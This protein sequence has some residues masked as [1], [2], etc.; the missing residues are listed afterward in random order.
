MSN[1]KHVLVAVDVT[2]EAAEV[3][4]KAKQA[5]ADSGAQ[6]SAI[7]VVRPLTHAYTGIEVAGL[8]AAAVNFEAEA[9]ASVEQSLGD[10]CAAHGIDAAHRQVTFGVPA[11]EIKQH[12]EDIGADLVVLGSHGRHGLGLLLGS[13]ANAVLHGANCDILTVRVHDAA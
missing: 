1:Y 3:L 9:R 10:V 11:V 6:L 13:T 2:E 7:T 8:A 5:A 4:E 12:A